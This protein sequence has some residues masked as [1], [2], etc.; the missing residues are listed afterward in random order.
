[1]SSAITS[2]SSLPSSS[3][4]APYP[5][6]SLSYSYL[7]HQYAIAYACYSS[8]VDRLVSSAE[9]SLEPRLS[10]ALTAAISDDSSFI[11]E[12]ATLGLDETP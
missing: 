12:D 5:A 11:T 3:S 4:N 1:M 9:S 6:G 10:I 8:T 7:W 2:F